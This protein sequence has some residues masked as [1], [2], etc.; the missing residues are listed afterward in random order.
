MTCNSIASFREPEVL[1]KLLPTTVGSER[2]GNAR[3]HSDSVAANMFTKYSRLAGIRRS[4]GEDYWLAIRTTDMP[5]F[6]MRN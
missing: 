2:Q 3:T 6:F 4:E 1:G 5:S